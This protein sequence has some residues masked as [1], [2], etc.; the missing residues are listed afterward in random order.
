MEKSKVLYGKNLKFRVE[1][2][3]VLKSCVFYNIAYQYVIMYFLI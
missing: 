2:S 3:K 1:K